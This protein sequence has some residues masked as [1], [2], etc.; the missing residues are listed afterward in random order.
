MLIKEIPESSLVPSMTQKM[1]LSRTLSRWH[2]NLGLLVSRIEGNKF[3]LLMS[4][5]TG[6]F[7]YNHPNIKLV[8]YFKI[9]LYYFKKMPFI[10]KFI[11]TIFSLKESIT[12][13]YKLYSLNITTIV[14]C[15][16]YLC[17][18]CPYFLYSLWFWHSYRPNSTL[19]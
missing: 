6:V 11:D 14:R 3:L 12:L 7:C 8:Y 1:V 18:L 2:S 13:C 15:C 17:N 4:R 10:F 9:L 16:I 5:Q 19:Y